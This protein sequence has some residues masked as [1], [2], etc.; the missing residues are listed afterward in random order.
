DFEDGKIVNTNT[1]AGYTFPSLPDFLV[2]LLDVGLIENTK[3]K[4]KRTG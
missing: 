1:S 4:L 3:R 2:D